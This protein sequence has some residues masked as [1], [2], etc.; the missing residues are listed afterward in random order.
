[1]ISKQL[2]IAGHVKVYLIS[3]LLNSPP[4]QQENYLD[5][6]IS[7]N[8]GVVQAPISEIAPKART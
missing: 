7:P 5:L 8:Q 2:K 1:M 4:I 6:C 3:Q